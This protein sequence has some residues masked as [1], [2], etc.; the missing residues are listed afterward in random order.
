MGRLTVN[1][2]KA[3]RAAGRYGDGD[4]LYLL[5]KP[6]G[7]R[8]WVLRVQDGGRRRDIG[9]GAV[10]TD[11]LIGDHGL[12]EIPVLHRKVLTLA[13]AREKSAIL[14]QFAKA[15]R[16]P[17]L[18]RDKDRRSAPTFKEAATTCHEELSRGWASK[19]AAAF[20][21]SLEE[22]AF[23][24]AKVLRDAKLPFV[25]HGFRS[26]FRDW[27]A[28]KMHRIPDP[29]AEAALAHQVPDDMIAAY[30]RTKFLDLRRELL[31]AWGNFVAGVIGNG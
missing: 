25:P 13:E 29:V 7:A 22:H 26:S 1:G 2:I 31:E 18:E 8:S 15:G 17:I 10:Q 23:P 21:A 27:A 11:S 3:K 14:R 16:D 24:V 30:K 9:L 6:S 19:H 28:E 12:D 20:F 4:G 5:V